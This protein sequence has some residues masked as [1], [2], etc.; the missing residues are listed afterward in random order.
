M[1][2][3]QDT[4]FEGNYFDYNLVAAFIFSDKS[5]TNPRMRDSAKHIVTWIKI[6]EYML[7]TYEKYP[8][9]K[10]F[11]MDDLIEYIVEMS[12]N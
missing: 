11:P 5:Y 12:I 7:G 9:K 10:Q 2:F 8:S 6:I 3:I 4:I 1:Q